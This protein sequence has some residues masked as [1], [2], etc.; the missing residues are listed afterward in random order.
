L[1]RQFAAR[2]SLI[3]Y[4]SRGL[5]TSAWKATVQKA[6]AAKQQI[7]DSRDDSQAKQRPDARERHAPS[8]PIPPH[9]GK[10]PL[11]VRPIVNRHGTC[12]RSASNIDLARRIA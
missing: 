5:K 1:F 3:Q 6:A 10:L 7:E 11:S 8:L 9:H 4:F 12:R 2:V